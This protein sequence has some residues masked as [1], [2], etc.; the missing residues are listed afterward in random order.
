MDNNTTAPS[1]QWD[2]EK[3]ARVAALDA[4]GCP[5]WQIAQDIGATV[6]AVSGKIARLGLRQAR[7]RRDN[8][9][10]QKRAK[11]IADVFWTEERIAALLRLKGEGLS[12]SEIAGEMGTTKGSVL[13]KLRRLGYASQKPNKGK[14]YIARKRRV[15][16]KNGHPHLP[17]GAVDLLGLRSADCRWPVTDRPPHLFCGQPQREGSSYCSFHSSKA[18][19]KFGEIING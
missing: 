12:A 14:L 4:K 19:K 7:G 6:N 8:A 10:Q 1:F 2:D 3:I 17:K 16:A 15:L 5:L 13:G 18:W 9:A 11:N